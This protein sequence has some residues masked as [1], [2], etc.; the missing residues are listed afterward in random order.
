MQKSDLRIKKEFDEFAKTVLFS[1]RHIV[2]K[3]QR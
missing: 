2:I 3:I 1:I